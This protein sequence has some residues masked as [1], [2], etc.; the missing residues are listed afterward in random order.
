[1][2]VGHADFRA[3]GKAWMR[4]CERARIHALAARR[5][6]AAIYRGDASRKSRVMR[7][8]FRRWRH[9]GEK[10]QA[11]EPNAAATRWRITPAPSPPGPFD[12]LAR[13]HWHVELLRVRGGEPRSWIL[14]ACD[15]TGHLALPA[16]LAKRP[17]AA[18]EPRLARAG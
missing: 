10:E 12:E 6:T 11:T 13:Q 8:A 9:A 18:G 5:A 1:M 2:A 16:A 14:D 3:K 7:D 17:A 4:G 15:A